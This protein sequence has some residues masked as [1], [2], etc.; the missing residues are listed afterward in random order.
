M[1]AAF[2]ACFLKSSALEK[3]WHRRW[4]QKESEAIHF[5][6]LHCH[7]PGEGR[8]FT[9]VICCL[10]TLLLM[11]WIIQTWHY[12]PAT[13]RIAQHLCYGKS[14]G[15]GQAISACSSVGAWVFNKTVLTFVSGLPRWLSG[16]ESTCQ[17]RRCRRWR[18]N[19]WA[20][21]IPWRRKWK[22]APVFLPG[23]SH[24]QRSLVGYSPW[25]HKQS[26]M[27]E[28]LSSTHYILKDVSMA[29]MCDCS[30]T[31]STHLSPG[32]PVRAS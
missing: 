18:F 30:Y 28:R 22:P 24:G 31:V 13:G 20:G 21:K 8:K 26:D 15:L 32:G 11:C 6:L 25:G 7:H 14:E 3:W 4:L 27:S 1:F 9:P 29:Y 19:P 17:C 5:H 23:E 2:C 16:K 12:L 10:E